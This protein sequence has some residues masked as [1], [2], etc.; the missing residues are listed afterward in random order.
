MPVSGWNS[1]QPVSLAR[2]SKCH[3]ERRN[4]PSVASL[5]PI[6]ACLCTTFSISM[7]S[8]LRRSSAE[9]SPFSR[10]ARASL[11]R[12]GLS[13]L[14]TSSARKGGFVRCMVSLPKTENSVCGG[15][16][17]TEMA[18]QHC[19]IG[20]QRLARRIMHDG[21]AF[22]YHNAVGQPENLLRVLLDNDGADSRAAGNDADRLQKFLDDDRG[23][24]FGRLVQEQHLGIEGECPADR[25]HLLLAAGKLIAEIAA[26]LFQPGKH[27]VDLVD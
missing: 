4:S 22:Q 25:Q 11:M 9:I 8:T 16:G 1:S 17:H 13:R 5:R 6:E 19:G 26:P 2:K 14:P 23:E 21:A 12:C 3:Q 18:L 20:L 7:S 10:L 15:A 27:L 24:P